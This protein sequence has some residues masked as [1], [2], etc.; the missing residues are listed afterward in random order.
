MNLK[1]TIHIMLT[2]RIGKADMIRIGQWCKDN[3][4]IRDYLW[5][6]AQSTDGKVSRNA[7]W[8]MTV[9]MKT[10]AEWLRSLHHILIDRLLAETD[11]SKR[12]IYLQLLRAQKYHAGD[13][14]MDLLD[15]CLSKINSE[16]EPYA[17]RAFSIYIA[18]KQCRHYPEAMRELAQHLEM[19]QWQELSP[20]LKCAKDK[21]MREI[22][23]N[24]PPR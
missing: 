8:C 6:V 9:L 3:T 20:G 1:D 14:R 17:V 22:S 4:D 21:V 24:A 11:T 12:R 18:Y 10:E 19:L 15:W 5:E 23:K 7:L 2:G 16:T 13:C